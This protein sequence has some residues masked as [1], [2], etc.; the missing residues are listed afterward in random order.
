MSYSDP[1]LT[2][3]QRPECLDPLLHDW[4]YVERGSLTRRLTAL[5][6][7]AFSVCPLI[8][9]WQTLRDDE[10]RALGLAPGSTG[11]VREVQLCGHG[12]PWVHARSV[13]GREALA[14]SGL[15]LAELGTRSLGALLFSDPAFSR[16]PL[17]ACVY[18]ADWLPDAVRRPGLWARRSC[19]RQGA[20]GVLVAEVFLPALWTRLHEAN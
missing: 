7:G 20:L 8:E 17:Q 19:F 9:G 14:A 4:L 18:P 11:W 5:A 3:D 1:W 6:E 16:G 13:A 15:A 10:C 2:A 12:T